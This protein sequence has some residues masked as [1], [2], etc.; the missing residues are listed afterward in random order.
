M[1]LYTGFCRG[2]ELV[3]SEGA[4]CIFTRGLVAQMDL[5][6][7]DKSVGHCVFDQVGRIL[8]LQVFQDLSLMEFNGSR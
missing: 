4:G 8:Q 3:V 2:R 6:W 1:A 7:S 5:G